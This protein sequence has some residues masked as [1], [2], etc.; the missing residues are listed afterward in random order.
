M[1]TGVSNRGQFM[2]ASFLTLIA[3][4]M[5]FAVRGGILKDWSEQF[6]FTQL[7]LGTITGGGLVGF[8]IIIIAARPIRLDLPHLLYKTR[9]DAGPCSHLVT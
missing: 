4:G 3:A 2:W 1:T 5:G 6:G 9:R 7:E 8:G